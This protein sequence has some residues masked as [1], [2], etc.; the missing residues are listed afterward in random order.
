MMAYDRE[1]ILS[2]C[3]KVIEQEEV[4]T[5][6][7][8]CLYIAPT[9]ASLYDWGFDKLD[10]IKAA[11]DQNKVNAKAKLKRNWQKADAAP[12][13]QIAAFKLMA[14]DS[15]LEKL[16]ISKVNA[17]VENVQPTLVESETDPKDEPIKD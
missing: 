8:M 10:T 7:E 16:T 4:T 11:I 2:Q 13:L 3:L 14:D 15:E 12:V 9:R 5:F 1:E 6:E 17:K